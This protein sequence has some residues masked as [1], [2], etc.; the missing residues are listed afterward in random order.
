[1]SR[2]T[3][4]LVLSLALFSSIPPLYPNMQ[5]TSNTIVCIENVPHPESSVLRLKAKPMGFPLCPEDR[6]LVD[7]LKAMTVDLGGVGLAAPQIGISKQV[8]AI[9]IPE[10]AAHLRED[11]EPKAIHV[12]LNPEYETLLEEGEY[13]DFEGCYSVNSVMGKVPRAKAIRVC[14][15]TEEGVRVE[16]VERGFYARVLQHEIDHLNGV[17][18]IDR[19]TPDCPQGSFEEMIELRKQELQAQGKDTQSLD[20]ILEKAK[21]RCLIQTQEVP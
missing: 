20:R 4:Y 21:E 15:Y 8:A 17:L 18:I 11:I 6:A 14:Y 12:I 2:L 5:H 19:L 10:E 7:T 9:Y 13:R 16:A 3:P 1:M